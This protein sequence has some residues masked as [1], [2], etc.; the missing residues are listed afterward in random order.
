MND[1]STRSH[2]ESR[3]AWLVRNDVVRERQL[4][5]ALVFETLIDWSQMSSEDRRRYDEL[6]ENRTWDLEGTYWE[7]GNLCNALG[8]R[9]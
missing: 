6:I 4:E 5:R 9:D 7:L 8:W 3:I 1:A 2:H